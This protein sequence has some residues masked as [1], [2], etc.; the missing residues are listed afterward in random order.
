MAAVA[1]LAIGWMP[2][3]RGILTVII[4][5]VV[6]CGSVYLLL[7]TN[8]GARL[9]FLLSIAGLAA[10]MASMGAIWWA[11]G[12]GLKGRDPTWAMAKGVN[13]MRTP[14]DLDQSHIINNIS[15]TI[16]P[17]VSFPEQAAA[18][19]E[20]LQAGGWHLLAEDDPQR[21]QAIASADEII[22]QEF[23]LYA[24]GDYI[25]VNVF[26]KGGEAW[27][28]ISDALDFTALRHNPHYA[29]VEIAPV[30][31]Q[32]TEPGRAP[33]TPVADEEQPHEY[34]LMVRDLGSKRQPAT[35]LTLGAGLI[36]GATCW[37]LHRRDR[38]VASHLAEAKG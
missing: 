22:Q 20:Q 37:L 33:A 36:F 23:E 35:F 3:I 38:V 2:E 29:L 18:A 1:T 32:R 24:A 7:G 14:A 25:A 11:Y 5:V 31:P 8:V 30:V 12:L 34:V 9:G 16:D 26:D 17:N 21:G 27:P 4:A 19:D 28:K 13:L 10:W 6:F 15:I